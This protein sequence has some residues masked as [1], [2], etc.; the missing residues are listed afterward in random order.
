MKK[1]LYTL[2]LLSLISCGPG[3]PTIIK[4]AKEFIDP[5]PV[6]ASLAEGEDPLSSSQ[7][8]L[9][10]ISLNSSWE[11]YGKGNKNLR[12]AIV[13]SGVAYNHVDLAGNIGINLAERDGKEGVDDDGNGYI[14][15]IVGWDS[16]DEDGLAFDRVGHGSAQAGV[17]GAVHNNGVGIKGI[18]SDVSIIPIRYIGEANRSSVIYLINA[19]RYASKVNIDVISLHALNLDLIL[20]GSN[21]LQKKLTEVL[22]DIERQNIPIVVNAGSSR[23][24]FSKV[25]EGKVSVF[26]ELA[27][28]ANVLF[29]TSCDRNDRKPLIRNFG[30]QDVLTC[31]PGEDVLSTGTNN[32]YKSVSGSYIASAH[33]AGMIALLK[34]Y[35]PS[36][37]VRD[38]IGALTSAEGA[39]E[40]PELSYAVRGRNRINV[41]K[42]VS[43][44]K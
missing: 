30:F 10:K 14:D 15:D 25:T 12:I 5:R 17:I 4:P 18:N 2:S 37:L 24:E 16:V 23:S 35:R 41:D 32:D 31:A 13:G 42:F 43:V 38:I 36:T 40:V 34:S 19:L 11:K 20:K 28:R 44:F 33:V 27:T 8:T 22:S 21:A 9:D 26:S 3:G 29:V 1:Y 39:D 6:T 7:W